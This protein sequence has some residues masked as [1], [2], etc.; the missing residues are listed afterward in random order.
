MFIGAFL[1]V[2]FFHTSL[3]TIQINIL[4]YILNQGY[5]QVMGEKSTGIN[6]IFHLSTLQGKNQSRSIKSSRYLS[7]Y[8]FLTLNLRAA[9][10]AND[11]IIVIIIHVKSL[12]PVFGSS[13]N[14]MVCP[15]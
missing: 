12:S 9:M 7:Q 5:I 14:F 15:S 4:N 6:L 3:D 2:L 1:F 11:T 13:E 10:P 8:Y